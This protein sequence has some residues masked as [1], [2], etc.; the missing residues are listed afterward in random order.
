MSLVGAHPA[1]MT[2]DEFLE[3]PFPAG[4]VELAWPRTV[5]SPDGAFI[6]A[7]RLPP[8]GLAAGFVKLAPDL[9]IEVL[10]PSESASE[11]EEK[12]DDYIAAGMPLIWVI[13]PDRRTVMIV[14]P[15]APLRWLRTG[16]SLDGGD[17]LPGFVCLVSDLF[18]GLAVV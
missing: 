5:R 10:S 17:V 13:D 16:D 11:L 18:E 3:Y 7:E 9:A 4:K 6:R 2:V 14:S 15:G 12:L 8:G 1:Q